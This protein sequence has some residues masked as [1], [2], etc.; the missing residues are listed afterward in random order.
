M[1]VAEH[2]VAGLD[3]ESPVDEGKRA[4][5]QRHQR[6]PRFVLIQQFLHLK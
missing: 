1:E 6:Q 4:D 5:I 3:A 2:I